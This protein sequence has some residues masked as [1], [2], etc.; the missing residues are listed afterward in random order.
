MTYLR[1]L[2][3]Y[4]RIGLLGELEYRSNFWVQLFESALSLVVSIGSLLVVYSHTDTLAGWLAP[5]LLAL[6]AVFIIVGGVINLLIS[7]SMQRFLQ[8]VRQGTLDFPLTKP[9]DAQFHVSIRRFEVWKAI[10][11]VLGTVVLV[12]AL[13]LLG[14][15]VGTQQALSFLLA[16][17]AGSVVVYSFWM[18]LATTAFWIVRAENV[19]EIFNALF[20]AA[21]WPVAIYPSW[22]RLIM[23]FIVPIAFAVTVPAQGLI[24]QLT[25]GN[26]LLALGLALAMF[27]AA[28]LFWR[29]GVRH[30]SGASA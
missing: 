30:Y 11:I 1:V 6:M 24:G 5:Q 17:V 23:T 3:T 21:R 28:R 14:N 2:L 12:V 19:F 8:D 9:I 18:L 7:P 29:Y 26:L 13:S 15:A 27:V 22:L 4:F 20:S 25:R 10:D 16:L